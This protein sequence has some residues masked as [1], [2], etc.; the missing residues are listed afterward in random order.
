MTDAAPVAE[1]I[2]SN[3]N[4]FKSLL[5]ADSVNPEDTTCLSRYAARLTNRMG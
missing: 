3:A 5:E 4:A 1:P 2:P